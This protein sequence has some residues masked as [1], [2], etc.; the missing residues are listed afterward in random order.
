MVMPTET[1]T[2]FRR[3]V[4][5]VCQ[6]HSR[7]VVDAVRD[8]PAALVSFRDKDLKAVKELCEGII[9]LEKEANNLK[10]TLMIELT[11]AGAL[12]ISREDFLRLI[13]TTTEIVDYA[14]GIAFRLSEMANREW[15]I[16]EKI[17]KDLINLSEATVSTVAKLREAIYSLNY[18]AEKTKEA[19]KQVEDAEAQVDFLYRKADL[20]IVNSK[21]ELPI[22]LLLRD[23]ASFL[24]EIADKSEDGADAAR[25]LSLT[26]L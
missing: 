2:L 24:E 16:D 5:E 3:R 4:L 15:K 26:A 8:L 17:M 19:A 25:I 7:K 21:M 20:E 22:I 10:R 6:E 9:I 18:N 23:V 11:R 14:V 1:V 12:L 13:A